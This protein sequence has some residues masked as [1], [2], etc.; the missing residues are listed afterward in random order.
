V[1]EDNLINQK[2]ALATLNIL[3]LKADV[4]EDGAVALKA[5][6]KKQYALILMDCQMPVMNG[7]E[8]TRRIRKLNA[9]YSRTPIVAWTANV[10]PSERQRCIDCGMDDFLAKPF[11]R[12]QL[13]DILGRWLNEPKN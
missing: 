6:E 7:Y 2:V 11:K 12:G 1:V 4:V 9:N 8:A 3:G 5:V 10:T 13:V